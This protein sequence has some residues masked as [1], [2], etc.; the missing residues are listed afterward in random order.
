MPIKELLEDFPLYKKISISQIPQSIDQLPKVPILMI[1]D[2]CDEKQTFNMINEYYN[3]FPYK[4]FRCPDAI[5]RAEYVCMHCN[6]QVREFFIKIDKDE[7][8]LMKVGQYPAW[9]INGE[10]NL[11]DMLGQ[12]KSY[13]KKGLICESQGYG[14][15]AF[16]YYRR[17]VE[18][19]IDE[20]LDDIKT[21]INGKELEIYNEALEKTKKTIV[22][23]EKIHLVK[24]L[25]PPILRPDGMNPLQ[26]LHSVLSEGLHAKSDEECLDYADQS[27]NIIIFLINQVA[28]SKKTA[29]EFSENMKK[30]LSKKR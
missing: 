18:E 20:L 29:L 25:L 14:I 17:I 27:R 30:I 11:E 2:T 22:A 8:W 4:N 1:C 24:E 6:S 23:Q 9:E 16:G 5:I 21:L 26:V 3:G 19:I 10:K 15:G 13:Y 28:L 12:Y 7:K